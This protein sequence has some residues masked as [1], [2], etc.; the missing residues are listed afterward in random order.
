MGQDGDQ[1]RLVDQPPRPGMVV[2]GEPAA[3]LQE[4]PEISTEPTPQELADEGVGGVEAP[5][6]E[7]AKWPAEDQDSPEY[8]HLTPISAPTAFS[9]MPDDIETLIAAN[10]FQPEGQGN[11]IALAIRGSVLQAPHEQERQGSIGLSDVRPNHVNFRCTLG[12]Y[13]RGERKLTLFT[14]STVPCPRYIKNHRNRVNGQP[15]ESD[16]GCNMLPSGCYV[17]RVASHGGGSIRPALRMTDSDDMQSDAEATV[18]RTEDDLTFGFGAKDRWDKAM[19]FDNVHCSYFL[20]MQSAYGAFFSSAGCL[21]VRGRKDPSDQWKK[22]QG[23]L[24]DIGQGKRCDLVMLTGREFAIAAKLR[25]DGLLSDQATVRRE[26]VRLRCGSQ[27]EEVRR[28]QQKLGFT[29]PTGYFGPA[30]KKR[31]ADH[32]KENGLP[33]DGVFSQVLDTQLGWNVFDGAT[34]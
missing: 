32:Q 22:F 7:E 29:N 26:L 20:N 34:T 31:L 15:H 23:E 10:R 8:R 19:P 2:L 27:G 6:A 16:I 17:F 9:L 33:A 14:G 11:V 21:T 5:A 24:D 12:F 3:S 1:H 13:F 18:L 28:M 25:A 4:G 30:T